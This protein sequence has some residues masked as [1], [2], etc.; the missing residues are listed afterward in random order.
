MNRTIIHVDMDAFYAA[1]EIRDN[2]DLA[3]KPLI[4]G[5]LPHERGVVA[6]CSYEAR[7]YGLHSAMS[8]K[9]AYRLCPHGIYMHPNGRKY[10]EASDQIHRIW[11][12]YTDLVEYISLDEG[13]LDITGSAHIF[14]GAH[15][16]GQIIKDR[17]KK[18][19]GLT[20]SVG[21]G[22]SKTTAKVASEEK[23]PDGFF[24]VPDTEFW[25][26]L[27]LD[28]GVRALFTVGG[29]TAEKLELA[30]IRTIR[31]IL[32]NEKKVIWMLGKHGQMITELAAGLDE[33][34][35][36]PYYREEA[37]SIG[38]EVTFQQ[39]TEDLEYLKDVL[40]LLARELS[41]KTRFENLYCR[42]ITLK[43]TYWNMK[44]ITRSKSA[45][46][47]NSSKEIYKVTCSLLQTI[48]KQPIRLIGISLSHLSHERLYQ[49]TLEDLGAAKAEGS[50]EELEGRLIQLQRKYG[51][52]IIKTAGELGAQKRIEKSDMP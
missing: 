10:K 42:T 50:K 49:T 41:I 22:Y 21:I 35:V 14:G 1:V 16:I 12:D 27:M 51:V 30:G 17:T 3:G 48:E 11:N 25:K 36:I 8:I 31:D 46:T 15:A 45:E 9:T 43:I 26:N 7:K 23:K 47:T 24:E 4:I 28:R 2:P 5:A 19:T 52:D 6:T 33:R 13:Y 20:C 39:D 38:R 44:S 34:P 32:E 18:E 40:L 37:K 29:K